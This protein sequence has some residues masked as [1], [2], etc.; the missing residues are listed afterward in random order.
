MTDSRPTVEAPEL[1]RRLVF[2]LL[3]P[4]VRLCRRFR[5]PLKTLEDLCR[6]A[7]FEEARRRGDVSQAEVARAF[8][9]SLRT[10]GTLEKQYRGNFLAPE[11]EIEST[12]AV[13]QAFAHGPRTVDEVVGSLDDLSSDE[14]RRTIVGLAA[15]GRIVTVEGVPLSYRLDH[16]FVSLVRGD[17]NARVDGLN[18]QLDVIGQAVSARFLSPQR[19]SVARSLSFVATPKG[20]EALG[21][22]L[23][24]E[25]RGRVIET[26]EAALKS[27]QPFQRFGVTMALA[28]MENDDE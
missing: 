14:V 9:K 28:P 8:G 27:G 6:L 25:L 11:H 20:V 15:A 16:R 2:S 4:V 13:E 1:Q 21:D 18:H 23:V 5:L 3:R 10:I 19:E 7:Y 17:L 26:E 24:R 22:E 12:R